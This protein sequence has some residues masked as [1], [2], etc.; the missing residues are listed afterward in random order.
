MRVSDPEDGYAR[1]GIEQIIRESAEES[2]SKTR[3]MKAWKQSS[4]S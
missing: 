4:R 3:R 2:Q 1:P